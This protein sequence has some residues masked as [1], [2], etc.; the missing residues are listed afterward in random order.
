[1]KSCLKQT[2]PVTPTLSTSGTP[3]MS[4]CASPDMRPPSIRKSVSFCREEEGLEEVF[5]ADDW[6]RS[7]TPMTPRLS[8]QDILELKQLRLTLPRAPPSPSYRQPFTTSVPGSY[9]SSQPSSSTPPGYPVARLAQ[10]PSLTPSRWKNREEPK[11]DPE[12][13]PYLDAVPIQLL[14]LLDTPPSSQP[15][16]P[17]ASATSQSSSS[18]SKESTPQIISTT[19]TPSVSVQ[20][21]SPTVPLTPAST[22]SIDSPTTT[23]SSTPTSSPRRTANFNFLPLLPVQEE[24]PVQPQPVPKPSQLRKFNMAF[25][26]LMPVAE[27]V[28]APTIMTSGAQP[29]KEVQ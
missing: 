21:P 19:S 23:P 4:R 15:S 1:M 6:D 27:P 9:S 28:P 8:Y 25:V 29:E 18:D 20:P 13:L 14:P 5:E 11:V 26:P 22:P 24:K 10:A 17:T 2:P 16:T 12:I 7:P 3:E